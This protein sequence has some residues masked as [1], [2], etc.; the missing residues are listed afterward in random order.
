MKLMQKLSILISL[1][2]LLSN[3]ALF[4]QEIID[5][6]TLQ[7]GQLSTPMIINDNWLFS[8]YAPEP[9]DGLVVFKKEN[10]NWQYKETIIKSNSYY[11][12]F[13]FDSYNDWLII[14]DRQDYDE[15]GET[16]SSLYFY[17][18]EVE[19]GWTYKQK[20]YT[21]YFKFYQYAFYL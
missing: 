16:P 18:N 17:K 9:I 14:G 12:G 5:E 11:F 4:A 7:P 3:N 13:N 8:P 10:D 21:R 1:L 6:I 15:S 19:K 20:I 2:L